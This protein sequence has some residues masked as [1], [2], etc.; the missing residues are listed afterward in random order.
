[1]RARAKIEMPA[2]GWTEDDDDGGRPFSVAGLDWMVVPGCRLAGWLAP[3]VKKNR[4]STTTCLGH[5]HSG[6]VWHCS[7]QIL[8]YIKTI[9]YKMS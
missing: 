3:Q 7:F 1:L 2:C 9:V 8:Q 6:P 4:K 5:A